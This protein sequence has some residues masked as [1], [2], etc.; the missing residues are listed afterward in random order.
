MTTCEDC[1]DHWDCYKPCPEVIAWIEL[2]REDRIP[3][4]KYKPK[5]IAPML[6][7]AEHKRLKT[8]WDNND[9]NG[10]NENN[11]V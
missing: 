8:S 4:K 9:R 11:D 1:P 2:Q 10:D 7:H 6:S 3:D 5:G